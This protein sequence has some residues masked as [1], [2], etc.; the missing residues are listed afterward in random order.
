[1]FTKGTVADLLKKG[2]REQRRRRRKEANAAATSSSAPAVTNHDGK[3]DSR[4]KVLSSPGV[5]EVSSESEEEIGAQDQQDRATEGPLGARKIA[6]YVP[7]HRVTNSDVFKG[8]VMWPTGSDVGW[9]NQVGLR[10]GDAYNGYEKTPDPRRGHYVCPVCNARSHLSEVLADHMCASH[11]LGLELRRRLQP[12]DEA[13]PEVEP[14][15]AKRPLI[16]AAMTSQLWWTKM[17]DPVTRRERE[18]GEVPEEES[19]SNMSPWRN[20]VR[21]WEMRNHERLIERTWHE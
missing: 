16:P 5:D 18:L 1:M 19:F 21:A 15:T 3:G 9:A 10:T 8:G 11:D 4:G 2:E 12:G 20:L 6:K 7:Y 14:P 13:K 17:V